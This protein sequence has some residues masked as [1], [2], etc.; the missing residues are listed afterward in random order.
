M[1]NGTAKKHHPAVLV[2]AAFC[3]AI[4]VTPL[5]AADISFEKAQKQ[6]AENFKTREGYMYL[7]EFLAV[8]DPA[9]NRAL[10]ICSQNTPF[11]VDLQLVFLISAD[12]RS[13]RLLTSDNGEKARC[14]IR[15]IRI[16]AQ[17][18]K[19]PRDQWAVAAAV[20]LGQ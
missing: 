4:A 13:I 15:E 14:L 8:I 9:I 12:G 17:V 7:A 5:A 6:A 11:P 18:P 10:S 16:P 19:P 20:T 2:L 1:T 3:V